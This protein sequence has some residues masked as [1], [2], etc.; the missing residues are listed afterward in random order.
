VDPS[1]PE[2]TVIPYLSQFP[3]STVG[4]AVPDGGGLIFASGLT[5]PDDGMIAYLPMH[6]RP[7]T[8]RVVLQAWARKP[9]QVIVHWEEDQSSVFGYSGFGLDYGL[10]LAQ[11]ISERYE[12]AKEFPGRTSVLVLRHRD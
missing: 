2:A 6:F 9:P 11:W 4:A 1:S 10:E 3:P 8:E 5:P 12:V 7:A